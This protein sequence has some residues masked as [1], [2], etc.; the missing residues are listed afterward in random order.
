MTASIPLA[1]RPPHVPDAVVYDFDFFADPGLVRD[2][3][4]RVKEIIEEAPPLFWTPRNG[5]HWVA[6]R[7]SDVVSILRDTERFSSSLTTEEQIAAMASM[8]PRGS[9]RIPQMTPIFMDPPEHTKYRAPLQKVF[10]PKTMAALTGDIEA[11]ARGLIDAIVDQ[12]SCDFL[13][14]VA[15]QLPV[16]VFLRMMGLSADRLAEFRALVRQV[17]APRDP[18][19]EDYGIRIRRIADSMMDAILER[20]TAPKDDLISHLWAVEIDG[21]AMTLELMEDYAT[22]LFLA[23]LDTVIN[24]ICLGMRHLALNPD[25]QNRLRA[26]PEL[27][28]EA[29][30]ELLRRY[31]FNVPQR[32]VTRDTDLAGTA[33][34]AGDMVF[35]YLPATGLDPSEFD[36]PDVFDVERENKLHVAFGTG[37]H[38]CLGSHLA[39]IE[40]QTVYRV[41][42]ERLPTFRLD[43]S[44]P[45]R[46][47]TGN[48][49]AASSLHI[50][51]D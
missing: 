5:G 21:Q 38:R 20:R 32:R 14:A 40:L 45:I 13:P 41:A 29:T 51:W 24:G 50:R 46:F 1:A 9:A 15:E 35:T 3:H 36:A 44:K 11:L 47:H 16:R 43:P 42:L 31:T 30:E 27:I 17:F 37:P 26:H 49:L 2:P 12:G 23:G 34:K 39:R 6:L 18:A 48:M 33:L 25:L 22:L 19:L 28:P 10:S 4:E 7:Y 8:L